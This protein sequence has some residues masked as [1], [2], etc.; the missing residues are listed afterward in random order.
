MKQMMID[1]DPSLL[2]DGLLPEKGATG[3]TEISRI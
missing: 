2:G 3:H 1:A